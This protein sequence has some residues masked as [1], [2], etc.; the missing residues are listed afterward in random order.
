MALRD[1][2]RL[3]RPR[4]DSHAERFLTANRVPWRHVQEPGGFDGP[5]ANEMGVMTLPLMILVDQ[6][7]NVVDDNIFVAELEPELRQRINTA[8]ARG[9]GGGERQIVCGAA[10]ETWRSRARLPART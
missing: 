6:K 9:A 8:T 4:P 2:R 5:L 10:I 1:H 7:G 3:P